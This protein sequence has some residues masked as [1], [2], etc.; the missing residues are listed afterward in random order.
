[1]ANG[2]S[3]SCTITNND[4]P[5]LTLLKTVINNSGGT[6]LDTAFTLTA[7]GPVTISGVEGA[8]AVTNANVNAGTYALT[9]SALAGYAGGAWSCV[10]GTL[11]GSSLVL[12][13]NQN[14][15]CTVTNDDQAATLTLLKTVTNDN[16]GTAI[17]TD[18]TLT[19]TGPTTI[20]GIEGAATVTAAAVNA[21]TYV[22]TESGAATAAYTPG[23]WTCT[24]GTLTG[25]SLVLANGQ[26]ASCTVTNNDRPR[27][28]LLK[29]VLNDSG[30][31]A[32]DT[33]FTLTA[34]GPVTITG[35]EGA[36]A[37]TNANVN[38]GTYALTEST[39]AGYTG[40]AWSCVG[41]T[42]TGSNL[43][44]A[45]NQNAT[46]TVTNDDQAATLTLLK[47][48]TNDNGGTAIDTDFTLTATG[49]TTI[50][51]IEGAATVTAAAVNAGTYV[52]T[53]SGAATAGY[54][55]GAWTCTAGTLTGNSLVLT[56]GQS[57]SCT[58]TNND[59][60]RLTLL[61]TVINN[62]G[63]TALDTAFTLTATGPVT[64]SG[65]EGAAAITNANVN[66][67]TY[68]LSESSLAGY[69]GGAWS[70]VGGTLTGSSLVLGQNQNATC[71]VTN[72]D[73]AATLTLLKTV[74]NDNG[75]T[76]V[77]TD[78]TLT[79]TGPTTITGIEGAS[80]VTVAPVSAGTYV[81][82]ESG[83]ATAGY[84]PG[85]WTCTAGIL[86]GNS[87]ILANGQSASCTITNNDRPRLTLL[88]TVINN[89]G[90]TALDTAFTLT[91][92]GPVT[93]SGVE[94]AAAVTNANVNAGTY[95]LSESSLAGYSGGAWSCV[96]GTLTGSSLVL[97]QNQ[98]ATCTV[99]NTDQA[100][101]LTLLK[102]VINDNGGTA[103]DTDF[104]LT[105][106]G[107][108]NITGIEGAASVTSAAVGAG[109]YTLTESG[110][111]T[112]AYTPGAWTCTA[113]T[114]TGNSLVLAN[115]QSA[116]CTITNNDRPRLTLLKTVINN[117]GGTALDT[118]FTLTATGPVTISG[119]EG[120]VAVTN[121]NVNAGTYTLSESA[122]A[123]YTGG[124]WSCVGGTLTGSSLVLTQSQNA[125]C[126]V[127]NDDQAATLTLTK[128]IVNTG[129]GTATLATFP[130]TATGPTN[131]TGV[132]G[133]AAVTNRV[134][135]A[136]V[137]ALSEVTNSNYTA[138]AWSCTGGSLS[139]SNLTL[140]LGQSASCS[141]TNTFVPAP[142]LT[143]D[144]T[145]NTAGPLTAGQV[146]TY[147][148]LVTNTG[149]VTI[150][151]VTVTETAFNGT[152]TPVP[153][154]VP[155]GPTTLAPGASVTFTATYTV[156][157]Q[158]VDTLQ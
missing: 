103:V 36:A 22:L 111:A 155:T 133:T 26:S 7:A 145:A 132:S 156:T 92:T 88:K 16:G 123:G 106:T 59:R 24:A 64:A 130:L 147:S 37:I 73:Q 50:T 81:L 67:G 77:D 110:V 62:S 157:Q 47:T 107:P 21:G 141:I 13:Q 85:T 48:V 6:A 90:G 28:T 20:T 41:G 65:V 113:G 75:G 109:T 139:G 78:F 42:L 142:A 140:A 99:T 154:P 58:I 116:S 46:C 125:T 89:S 131:A 146:V 8:V 32:L 29:T 12:A 53:E 137:Y 108:T 87:L 51:G 39:L 148:Y 158:D 19:A 93:V 97:A 127:T 9:E 57:A 76:A 66:A 135:N 49:P 102:T 74:T 82:T 27:L 119:V 15:T 152:G 100:A 121:A 96:G 1:L 35:T 56:N 11:T 52:L 71:T 136:G 72:D 80:A 69:A 23:A 104:T 128:V 10:G 63:G 18:F 101:T 4:R 2:Q 105:A 149:N 94:G 43:A 114:L 83:A 84:T 33:A 70:C 17:D 68:T 143:I 34:T 55:P 115:G 3:A 60:P 95:T 150:S 129:G 126:T 98:N 144:K 153:N 30:G 25:N 120:A 5:R 151:G 14:A 44:L 117:S 40:G 112:A 138:S 54:T 31:T 79:A 91:A 61:K 38:A 134:V 124:A 122:L 45:Q 118:A 86:T